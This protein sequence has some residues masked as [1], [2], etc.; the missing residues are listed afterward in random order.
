ML[1]V[2]SGRSFVTPGKTE[3]IFGFDDGCHLRRFAEKRRDSHPRINAFLEDV[4]VV[5]ATLV[6]NQCSLV[7]AMLKRV[8][9]WRNAWYAFR[10]SD[11]DFDISAVDAFHFHNHVVS[12]R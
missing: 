6:P 12:S 5:G 4:T 1:K 11:F 3:C 10:A 7:P 9:E 2:Y 8:R